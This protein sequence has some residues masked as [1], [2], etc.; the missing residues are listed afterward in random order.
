MISVLTCA[1]LKPPFKRCIKQIQ[2][3]YSLLNYTIKDKY[4][5]RYFKEN[6][7]KGEK[8]YKE[9]Q[10]RKIKHK[11]MKPPSNIYLKHTTKL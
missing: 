1:L 4:F 5:E 9:S 11:L 3:S 6:K 8:K 7:E 10:N 2:H